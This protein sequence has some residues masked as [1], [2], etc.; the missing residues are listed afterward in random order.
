MNPHR[1]NGFLFFHAN[2]D[3]PCD[4]EIL[5]KGLNKALIDMSL[6]EKDRKNKEKRKIAQRRWIKAGI[7]F[8]SWR[9]YYAAHMAEYTEMRVVQLATGHKNAA[10]AEHYANHA[11]EKHFQGVLQAVKLAFPQLTDSEAS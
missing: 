10:M 6:S 5:R 4:G 11:D 1:E 3:H 8:H 2:P 9:H 7:S